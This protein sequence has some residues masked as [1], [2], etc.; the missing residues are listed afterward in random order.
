MEIAGFDI[1]VSHTI[2]R[3]HVASEII[4]HWPPMW[5]RLILRLF[6][7]CEFVWRPGARSYEIQMLRMGN[8]IFIHPTDY[9]AVK[10]ALG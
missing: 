9:D 4:Q 2:P 3:K 5:F 1:Y 8:K 7:Q 10:A 6:R